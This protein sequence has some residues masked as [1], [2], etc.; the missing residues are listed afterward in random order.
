MTARRSA[1]DAELVLHTKHIRVVEV[2]KVRCTP[3]GIEV[4][5]QQLKAHTLRI[6]IALHAIIDR[7]DKTISIRSR[8]SHRFTQIMRE[9]RD[10]AEPG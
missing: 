10:P 4:F 1:V 2:Q 5:L 3:I 9:R 6:L 7:T 8:S